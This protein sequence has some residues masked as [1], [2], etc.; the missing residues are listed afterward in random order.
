M[1]WD[2]SH[3]AELGGA[4]VIVIVKED[5]ICVWVLSFVTGQRLN[6]EEQ[7]GK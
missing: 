6:P 2:F 3:L 7:D 1:Y 4:Q 5:L